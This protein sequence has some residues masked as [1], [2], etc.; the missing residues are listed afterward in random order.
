MK[1]MKIMMH[2]KARKGLLTEKR[3]CDRIITH[4]SHRCENKGDVNMPPKQRITR[5]MILEKSFAMFCKDGMEAVN[6]RSVAKVL[7]CSTQPIFSYFA[8]MDDLKN[9]LEQ[10]ALETFEATIAGASEG[11]DPLEESC[12]AYVRFGEEQPRLLSHLFLRAAKEGNSAFNYEL[13]E[14]LEEAE[15]QATGLDREKAHEL[16]RCMW[17]FA[18]GLAALRAVGKMPFEGDRVR[19]LLKM[20]REGMVMRLKA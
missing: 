4:S 20:E 11:G 17:V 6:A 2:I 19:E 3:D 12:M 13:L 1:C 5:D 10:K 18:H 16:C 8:G 7:N 15:M 14:R 9:A